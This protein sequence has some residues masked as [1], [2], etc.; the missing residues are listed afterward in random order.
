MLDETAPL[1]KAAERPAT[2]AGRPT[3]ST[4]PRSYRWRTGC[5]SAD[6]SLAE[7]PLLDEVGA[8]R[9]AAGRGIPLR[10][11]AR[12]GGHRHRAVHLGV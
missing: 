3:R 4:I 1:P 5:T 12:S 7:Q 11:T 10:H 9:D 8:A 2:V 6:C